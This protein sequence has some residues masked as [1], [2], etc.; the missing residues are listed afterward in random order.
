[1]PEVLYHA[2]ET[3]HDQIRDWLAK[4]GFREDLGTSPLGEGAFS[5]HMTPPGTEH[6]INFADMGFGLSQVLPLIVESVVC[7]PSSLLVFE[8]PEIHLNPKLQAVLAE[9]LA[10]RSKQEGFT[11]VETHSEHLLLRLRRLVATGEVDASDVALYYVERSGDHSTVREVSI[12]SN[13]HIR[14]EEWPSGFFGESL[15]ES[16]QLALAQAGM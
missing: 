16:I 11:I 2:D 7:S 4:F 9:L 3:Q 15:D 14:E 8:Q 6:K 5:I 1:M 10:L 12:E 13:G